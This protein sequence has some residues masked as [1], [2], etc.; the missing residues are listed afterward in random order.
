MTDTLA[1]IGDFWAD[2]V[3]SED[4]MLGTPDEMKGYGPE[5]FPLLQLYIEMVDCGMP[6]ILSK[7]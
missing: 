2:S 5:G 3:Q 6:I 1:R 7:L 4:V